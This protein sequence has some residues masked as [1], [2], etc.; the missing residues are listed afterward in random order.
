MIDI[1]LL[2]SLCEKALKGGNELL[3]AR[4]ARKLSEEEKQ[5]LAAAAQQGEFYLLSTEEIPAGWIRVGG[6]NF[7]QQEDAAYA[8]RYFEAF[9]AL[10][11]RGYIAYQNSVFVLTG[12]GFERARRLN[13]SS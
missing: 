12:T 10:C 1:A 13:R 6:R 2:I 9:R 3:K 4:R 11:E 5:L 7:L 8:A